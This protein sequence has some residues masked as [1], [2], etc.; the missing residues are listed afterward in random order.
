MSG[1]SNGPKVLIVDD[2]RRISDS[3]ALIFSTHGYAA[4]VAY[5]AEEAIEI[6]A[7][8]QPDMAIVDVVLPRM[9]GLDLAI[10]LKAMYPNCHLLLFSAHPGAAELAEDAMKNG[11]IFE[12]LP[13]PLHP[14][15]LLDRAA[16]LLASAIV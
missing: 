15:H 4:R 3:L 6:L 12:I 5:S 1:C 14:S 2:E 13:K 8:W 9:N 11:H 10:A 7:I 16:S